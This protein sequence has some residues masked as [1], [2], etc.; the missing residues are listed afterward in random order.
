MG[1][2]FA[3]ISCL[4]SASSGCLSMNFMHNNAMFLIFIPLF[5]TKNCI[6]FLF[7]LI[8]AAVF[9]AIFRH[10]SGVRVLFFLCILIGV[11]HPE[12]F[13]KP[14][15]LFVFLFFKKCYAEI[16]TLEMI[17]E[18]YTALCLWSHT[19]YNNSFKCF[20]Q[21]NYLVF[22]YKAAPPVLYWKYKR[23]VSNLSPVMSKAYKSVTWNISVCITVNPI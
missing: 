16:L 15:P 13:S 2:L 11:S 22:M 23:L 3:N 21:P 4:L 9:Q 12:T 1:M 8:L 17:W 20:T 7:C 18:P 6:N 19:L 14:F 10:F 5:W